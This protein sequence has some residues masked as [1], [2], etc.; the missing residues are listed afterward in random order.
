MTIAFCPSRST[1]MLAKMRDDHGARWP[2][3][4]HRVKPELIVAQTGYM[5]GAAG[6]ASVLLDADAVERG[7]SPRFTLPDSPF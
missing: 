5:Q 6:I 3:A 1:R 7:K 2:Q 4:E